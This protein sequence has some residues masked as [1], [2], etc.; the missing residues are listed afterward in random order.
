M[1]LLT[2]LHV[3]YSSRELF[4][5]NPYVNRHRLL[6]STCFKK[7]LDNR[8]GTYYFV[9]MGFDKLMN[10]YKIV[11]IVYVKDDKRKLLGEVA[12][13]VEIF[14]LRKNTW[15]KIKNPGVPMIVH[16]DGTYVNGCYYWLEFKESGT[17]YYKN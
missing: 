7:L 16:E 1:L 2:D 3:D 14:S 8:D 15:R 9:G 11:R 17:A 13:K 4:L 10:D 5:W 6:V 12:P